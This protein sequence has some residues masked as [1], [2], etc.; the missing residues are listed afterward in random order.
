MS[1]IHAGAYSSV[2]P[3]RRFETLRVFVGPNSFG[4]IYVE[5]D[6]GGGDRPPLEIVDDDFSDEEM[7]VVHAALALLDQK[8]E[9]K[10][11]AWEADPKRNHELVASA[12]AA[13]TSLAIT[14]NRIAQLEA[15]MVE[16]N[17]KVADLDDAISKAADALA[18]R[19]SAMMA[20]D[21]LLSARKAALAQPVEEKSD[22][23]G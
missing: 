15:S 22:A 4:V 6:A 10:Y 9:P 11:A 2:R 8:I 20:L 23:P 19:Q 7:M 16:K 14:E 18:E 13:Q 17:A 1:T 21:A 12:V 5:P 3:K